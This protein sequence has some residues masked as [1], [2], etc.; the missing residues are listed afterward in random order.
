M[1]VDLDEERD[2]LDG[3]VSYVLGMIPGMHIA[4]REYGH[5]KEG[6]E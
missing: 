5:C 3:A 4:G 2:L 6:G 1:M